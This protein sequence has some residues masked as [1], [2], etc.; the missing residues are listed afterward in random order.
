MLCVYVACMDLR[1][2]KIQLQ[3]QVEF[4]HVTQVHAACHAH[5]HSVKKYLGFCLFYMWRVHQGHACIPSS[6]LATLIKSRYAATKKKFPQ[7]DAHNLYGAHLGT[8]KNFYMST[9]RTANVITFLSGCMA[10]IVTVT[11]IVFRIQ[12]FRVCTRLLSHGGSMENHIKP[13]LKAH[14]L[15]HNQGH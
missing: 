8:C 11:I 2:Y 14:S 1:M 13:E 7:N 10:V 15:R 12:G 4:R 9:M 5:I 3:L 6:F